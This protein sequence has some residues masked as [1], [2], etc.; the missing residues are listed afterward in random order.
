[1][2]KNIYLVNFRVSDDLLERLKLAAKAANQTVSQFLRD[3]I[4]ERIGS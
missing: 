4:K 3:C 1:M 2:T